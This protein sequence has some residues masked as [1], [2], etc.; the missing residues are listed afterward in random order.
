ME[1][2]IEYFINR[3]FG[4]PI[5]Y[6]ESMRE[7]LPHLKKLNHETPTFSFYM[8]L[9]SDQY[10]LLDELF[11]LSEEEISPIVGEQFPVLLLNISYDEEDQVQTE[12]QELEQTFDM[13]LI[14]FV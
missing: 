7:I 14:G 10:E 4:D 11:T 6:A 2:R 8:R 5:T 12:I 13:R 9:A 1:I 3:G